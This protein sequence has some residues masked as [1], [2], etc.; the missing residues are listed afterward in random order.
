MTPVIW[1]LTWLLPQVLSVMSELPKPE[2]PDISSA[3]FVHILTWEP[4]QGTPTGVYYNVTIRR[5]WEQSWKPVGGCERVQHQLRCNLTDAFTVKSHNYYTQ[6]TAILGQQTSLPANLNVFTPNYNTTL[7]T[8]LL[9]V[10]SKGRN[11]S[12]KLQPPI[13]HLKEAYDIFTYKLQLQRKGED[14]VQVKDIRGL[15]NVIFDD[16]APGSQYCVSVCFAD[17]LE[18]RKSNYSHPVCV[19]TNDNIA[20][21]HWISAGLCV[22]V[23]FLIIVVVFLFSTDFISLKRR[24]LPSVL[25][26]IHH[27]EEALA[28]ISTS[29][30]SLVNVEL[31]VPSSGEKKHKSSSSSSCDESDNESETESTRRA[32]KLWR[33]TNCLPTSSSFSS[34]SAPLS[35]GPEPQH[36]VI[37]DQT[38]DSAETHS[39]AGPN[40]IL[41]TET[42]SRSVSTIEQEEEKEEIKEELMLGE[43][44]CQDVNLLTLTFGRQE[45]E[46]HEQV[47]RLDVAEVE[48]N[49]PFSLEECSLLLV[50][51]SQTG[52]TREIAIETVSCSGEGQDTEVEE[53]EEESG[54]MGRPCTD[55]LRTLL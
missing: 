24:P 48:T 46:D 8:P 18:Q 15:E 22:L 12:V 11:L 9:T 10:T 20:T 53:E 52:E 38:L 16:L 47:L 28:L 19:F 4:G 49:T 41:N 44:G 7:E 45:E 31:A 51:P 29:L 3:N 17:M 5:E 25:T 43:G 54:Y 6:V 36:V 1:I 32:Y 27:M 21:D 2:K 42:D 55:V 34:S 39:S 40:H 26:S 23:I 13:K 50:Q 30:S 37:S 35:P 14:V 33:G